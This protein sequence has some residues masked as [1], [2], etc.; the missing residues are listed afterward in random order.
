MAQNPS[1][2]KPRLVVA[3]RFRWTLVLP[4]C[5]DYKLYLPN[6]DSSLVRHL[7]SIGKPLSY[8]NWK[9]N[10][11]RQDLNI[12]RPLYMNFSLAKQTCS[13]SETYWKHRSISPSGEIIEV[14]QGFY[15]ISS[16]LRDRINLISV[17]YF[18]KSARE[19]RTLPDSRLLILSQISD[20]I[21]R[22]WFA[23]CKQFAS[24]RKAHNFIFTETSSHREG[25]CTPSCSPSNDGA[26]SRSAHPA[27]RPSSCT[28]RRFAT[29]PISAYIWRSDLTSCLRRSRACLSAISG[30][31]VPRSCTSCACPSETRMPFYYGR[32]KTRAFDCFAFWGTRSPYVGIERNSD[33]PPTMLDGFHCCP[34]LCYSDLNSKAFTA[35]FRRQGCKYDWKR[36]I[37]RLSKVRIE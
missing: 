10:G 17:E 29:K 20:V 6:T 8:R 11:S 9:V 31:S 14:Q 12:H 21:K 36:S 3:Q 34:F 33:R 25:A 24:W 7:S 15:L 27:A 35:T 4:T 23:K 1:A 30:S 2:R 5:S 13:R 28:R 19:M 32:D 18:Q 22:K 37:Q 26:A 16:S